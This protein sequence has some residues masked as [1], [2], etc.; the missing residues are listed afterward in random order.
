MTGLFLDIGF[1]QF[2]HMMAA[3]SLYRQSDKMSQERGR[4]RGK[5]I[6]SAIREGDRFSDACLCVRVRQYLNTLMALRAAS[7]RQFD[8]AKLFQAAGQNGEPLR[9]MS[10]SGTLQ[11][12]AVKKS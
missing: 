12:S 4:S 3:L 7:T 2:V 9:I 5:E 6:G 8:E 1:K 11:P 10:W